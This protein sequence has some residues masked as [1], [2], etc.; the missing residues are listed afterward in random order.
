MNKNQEIADLLCRND[1]MLS[2]ELAKILADRILEIVGGGGTFI[3][4]G[5]KMANVLLSMVNTISI[6]DTESE[7]IQELSYGHRTLQQSFTRLCLAWLKHQAS[8]FRNGNYD[9]RNEASCRLANNIVEKFSEQMH[10]P[11]I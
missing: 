9:L 8:D 7:F 3:K 2:P 10:L 6:V 11:L 5:K 1:K 4:D